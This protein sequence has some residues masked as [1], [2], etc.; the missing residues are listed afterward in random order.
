MKDFAKLA[1]AGGILSLLILYGGFG[2]PGDKVQ[3]AQEPLTVAAASETDI[4]VTPAVARMAAGA[5]AASPTMPLVVA[6]AAKAPILG[7]AEWNADVAKPRV[8]TM[9]FVVYFDFNSTKVSDR[10][11]E[12]LRL[13]MEFAKSVNAKHIDLS[14]FADRA[15]PAGYN[16]KL[17]ER[18]AKVVAAALKGLDAGLRNLDVKG[19]GEARPAVDTPDGLAEQRNRRVEIVISA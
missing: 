5:T 14:G 3:Q 6:D 13:A 10:A 12:T 4:D 2:A 19:F 11:R 18:R 1:A 8:K 7:E 15:G 9:R 16:M 17:S